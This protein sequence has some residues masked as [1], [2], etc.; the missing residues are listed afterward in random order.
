[1]CRFGYDDSNIRKLYTTDVL[2]ELYDLFKDYS[3]KI[4][5]KQKE[6]CNYY[7]GYDSIR[8]PDELSKLFKSFEKNKVGKD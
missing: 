2:K 7:F 8:K 1:M 6:I 4:S 3:E 5:D